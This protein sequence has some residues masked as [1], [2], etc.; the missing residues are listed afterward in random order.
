[1]TVRGMRSGEVLIG[2]IKRRK[3]R[4][5]AARREPADVALDGCAVACALKWHEALGHRIE[6]DH[7][8]RIVWR[9]HLGGGPRGFFRELHFLTGHGARTIDDQGQCEVRRIASA[10]T[11]ERDG[12]DAREPRALPSTGPKRV[13]TARDKQCS[14]LTHVALDAC[15][16][17]C[18][19]LVHGRV[20]EHHHIEG[21]ECLRDA[22]RG[23]D[24]GVDL[25][26]S[27]HTREAFDA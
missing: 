2:R 12:E 6:A 14:A 23:A 9:E 16:R 18:W 3:N 24:I 10:L 15:L 1:M 27:E 13:L 21:C 17:V 7:E 26:R 25:G 5:S 20:R 4:R 19:H 8:Q 22:T 11:F